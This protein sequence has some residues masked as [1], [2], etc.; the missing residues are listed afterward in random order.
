M[1]SASQALNGVGILTR[2]INGNYIYLRYNFNFKKS[3]NDLQI[4]Q[5]ELSPN[6]IVSA[7]TFFY[8][9]EEE[10]S[11]FICVV[12]KENKLNFINRKSVLRGLSEII[13]KM[14]TIIQF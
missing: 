9:D 1:I 13:L 8:N 7:Q 4:F 14:I 11:G 5:V 3:T 12:N 10:L 2:T 6:S